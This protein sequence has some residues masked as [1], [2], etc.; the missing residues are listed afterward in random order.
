MVKKAEWWLGL[1]TS[2]QCR[3]NP[4]MVG[5]QH[6]GMSLHWPAIIKLSGEDPSFFIASHILNSEKISLMQI[7]GVAFREIKS[8]G[9]K[10]RTCALVRPTVMQ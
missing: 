2:D 10:F 4:D 9:C 1:T 3:Q 8:H 6:T 5:Y 7:H